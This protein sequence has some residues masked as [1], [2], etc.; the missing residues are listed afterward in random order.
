[1]ESSETDRVVV[2]ITREKH[3]QAQILVQQSTV[4]D[5]SAP[6]LALPGTDLMPGEHPAE[7]A[8]RILNHTVEQDVCP[9]FHKLAQVPSPGGVCH[10]FQTA[11]EKELPEQIRGYEW[12]AQSELPGQLEPGHAWPAALSRLD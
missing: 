4:T 3:D 10:V 7:A 2:C 9:V 8:F 6:R 11:P 5:Q 1:M 12:R